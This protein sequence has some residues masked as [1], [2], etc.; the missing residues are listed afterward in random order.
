MSSMRERID[1]EVRA[2]LDA[3]LE[4]TGPRGLA[5]IGDVAARRARYGELTALRRRASQILTAVEV[6][7]VCAPGNAGDPPA[8]LR[9]YRPKSVLPG[10]AC[11]Y[12][13]HGGGM[14]L[15]SADS[16]DLIAE[17]L[18]MRL[19]CVTVA[20]D[21][22]LAPENP[23]PAPVDDCYAGLQWIWSNAKRLQVDRQR[24]VIYGASAGG[25]LAAATTLMARDQEGPQIAYQLLANPMLDDRNESASSHQIRDLGAWDRDENIE[26]WKLLLDDHAGAKD[27]SA[28][29]APA[30]AESLAGLPP[31]FIDVGDLDVL[32]DE[33]VEFATRLM[34]SGVPVDLRV[35]AGAVHGS[36]FWAPESAL[37]KRIVDARMAALNHAMRG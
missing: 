19:D 29:A 15:G 32:R 31:T 33:G 18:T 34:Q 36:E 1:P 35:Y 28:Y 14:V 25:G 22:R 6:T 2:G 21:Y 17:P 3:Y 4:A 9:V 23:H 12:Y 37:A 13:I 16:T 30:R 20:V 10:G 5:S 8:R 11:L 27:I 7:D 26:A 24:I